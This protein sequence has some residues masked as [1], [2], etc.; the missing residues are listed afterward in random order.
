M[1]ARDVRKLAR[2]LG[3]KDGPGAG[4][5]AIGGIGVT[6]SDVI[7]E[8]L[9]RLLHLYVGV[10]EG[11]WPDVET[12]LSKPPGKY[13]IR[14]I[15]SNPEG[16]TIEILFQ[17]TIGMNKRVK[18]FCETELPRL[19]ELG[20]PGAARCAFC[21][22]PLAASETK[23]TLAQPDNVALPL[24]DA[25]YYDTSARSATISTSKPSNRAA[26]YCPSSARFWAD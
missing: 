2:E 22:K 4:Y 1:Y 25:C 7:N 10:P 16:G 3:L 11:G 21:G 13:G 20:F 15:R 24:H 8:T 26:R 9:L 6:I 18:S 14:S 19:A 5:G 23:W 17:P 12:A